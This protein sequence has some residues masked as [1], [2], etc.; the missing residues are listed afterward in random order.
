MS[1]DYRWPAIGVVHRPVISRI[2]FVWIVAATVELLDIFIR[3]FLCQ[4]GQLR[5]SAKKFFAGISRAIAAVVLQIAVTNLIH[6]A[7]HNAIFVFL[8]QGVPH[9]APDN[10]DDIPA[11]T[12]EYAL[13]FLNDLTVTTNRTIQSL[14]V[15][16]NHEDQV[17]ETFAPGF[18]D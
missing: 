16:V 2:D 13:K 6:C 7:L 12:P 9:S 10:L 14:Q 3:Q 5:I 1:Q 11:G 8:K 18:G 4:L 17:I 15:A